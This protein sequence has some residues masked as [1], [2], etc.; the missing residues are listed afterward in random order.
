[1][2]TT[3]HALALAHVERG[4]MR[5]ERIELAAVMDDDEAAVTRV[6]PGEGHLAAA[7]CAHGEAVARRDV[8]AGVH[9]AA[10]AVGRHARAEAR[11]DRARSPPEPSPDAGGRS[12]RAC[13]R[14]ARGA[15]PPRRAARRYAAPPATS[16][17]RQRPR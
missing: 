10:L 7:G 8:D 11:G 2:L 17:R 6:A 14:A 12:A 9:L 13:H 3:T 15:R 5:V 1:R 4:E 16:A